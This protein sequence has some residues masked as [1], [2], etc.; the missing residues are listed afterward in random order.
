[1]LVYDSYFEYNDI[2][3]YKAVSRHTPWLKELYPDYTENNTDFL[4][5][6]GKILFYMYTRKLDPSKCMQLRRLE[7]MTCC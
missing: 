3:N 6:C 1:M 7:M 5:N 4:Q 2:V